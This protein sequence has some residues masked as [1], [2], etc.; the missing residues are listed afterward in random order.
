MNDWDRA[1]MGK[2]DKMPKP[3]RLPTIR[4]WWHGLLARLIEGAI[5]T[6]MVL[7]IWGLLGSMIWLIINQ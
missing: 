3:S 5:V 1:Y 7:M 2:T 6:V 4:P